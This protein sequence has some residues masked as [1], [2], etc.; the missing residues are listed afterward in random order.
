M[1]I[2]KTVLFFLLLFSGLFISAFGQKLKTVEIQTSAQC[3]MCKERLE[4]NLI[5]GKG[6][7]DVVLDMKTKIISLTYQTKKTDLSTLKSAISELGY[8]ADDLIGNIK[9]YKNLPP[10][11]KKPGD[12]VNKN[13]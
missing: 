3:E 12:R 11:C 2:I 6:V 4:S 1:K 5:F 9:A 7:K 13:Y 8:D 10:C